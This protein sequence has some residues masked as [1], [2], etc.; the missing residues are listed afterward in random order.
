MTIR[1]WLQIN[2]QLL[3]SR[4]ITTARLDCL[5][6][7]EDQ[8][9]QD[10]SLLLAHDE[11][12]LS[13]EALQNLDAMIARRA[14]HIPLAY[15]R[16]V[17][18]FYGRSYQVNPAVLVPRPESE[19]IIDLLKEYVTQITKAR[20][21]SSDG[22]GAIYTRIP[23]DAIIDVGTGSGALAISARLELPPDAVRS[24]IA[25]DTDQNCL[26]VAANNAASQSARI[27]IVQ[28]DLLTALL[29]KDTDFDHTILLCNL[30]YVPDEYAFNQAARHEPRLALFGGPD[31][32]DLYRKLFEQLQTTQGRPQALFCESLPIQHNALEKIA[33]SAGYKLKQTADF[34]QLFVPGGV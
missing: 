6:L 33:A 34:I 31:G 19:T 13:P 12:E 29:E 21:V 18:E 5:V 23:I 7:L 24:V 30:P 26:A 25:I 9:H 10:R 1:Q 28:S 32:L 14:Q 8:L 4:G 2:T 11:Q 16:G 3:A 20:T 17:A 22:A 15:I 27:E